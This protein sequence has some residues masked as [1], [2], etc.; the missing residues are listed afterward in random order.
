MVNTCQHCGAKLPRVVD[1]FCPECRGALD[2]A[3]ARPASPVAGTPTGAAGGAEPPAA[4]TRNWLVG[5]AIGGAVGLLVA[6]FALQGEEMTGR[7]IGAA[8][9]RAVLSGS[10][11]GALIGAASDWRK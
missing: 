1:A 11:L 3:P 5:A 2:E 8:V 9:A 4:G 7:A 6:F 10:V